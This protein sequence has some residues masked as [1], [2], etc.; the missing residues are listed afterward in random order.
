MKLYILFETFYTNHWL[1]IGV[2]TDEQLCVE[3]KEYMESLYPERSYYIH[4][5]NAN[6]I[7][8]T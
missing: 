8:K 1:F 3:A 6:E 5:K 2:F 4:T 7:V